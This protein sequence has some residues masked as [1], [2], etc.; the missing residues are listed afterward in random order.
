MLSFVIVGEWSKKDLNVTP[1]S[2]F[3]LGT[4][5]RRNEG[6]SIPT[7]VFTAEEKD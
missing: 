4:S 7:T 3:D 1:E 5:W 6:V 2:P